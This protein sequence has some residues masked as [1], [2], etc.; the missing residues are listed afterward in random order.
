MIESEDLRTK[1]IFD[2]SKIAQ[3]DRWQTKEKVQTRD[4]E[5]IARA[6]QKA[7]AAQATPEDIGQQGLASLSHGGRHHQRHG[8]AAQ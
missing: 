8:R 5:K 2:G 3:A 6:G 4:Q 7:Q 1:G